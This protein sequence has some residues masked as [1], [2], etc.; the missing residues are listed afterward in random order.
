MNEQETAAHMIRFIEEKE[1]QL[2]INKMLADPQAKGDV[3]KAILDELERVIPN[4][5]QQNRI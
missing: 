3:V 1:R 2:Q 4:E 5:D